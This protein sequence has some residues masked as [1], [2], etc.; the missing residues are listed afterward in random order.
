MKVSGWA[1]AGVNVKN[2]KSL[3]IL[4]FGAEVRVRI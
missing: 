2:K 1:P 3:M 4:S